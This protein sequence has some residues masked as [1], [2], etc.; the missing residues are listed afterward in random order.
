M[1]K[2]NKNVIKYM[3]YCNNKNKYVSYCQYS[4]GTQQCLLPEVQIG[5]T[6]NS[7][8]NFPRLP[9][10]GYD[11]DDCDY[12]FTMCVNRGDDYLTCERERDTCKQGESP[13]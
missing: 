8:N 13:N 6:F 12:N 5:Y 10:S 2:R 9:G 4:Y 11:V 7:I 1:C 3:N